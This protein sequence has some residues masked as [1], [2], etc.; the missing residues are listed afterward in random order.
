MPTPTYTLI[1]SSTVTA[2]GGAANI[3]FSSIPNTYTDLMVK[4]SARTTDTNSNIR[5]TINGTSSGYSERMLYNSDGTA[6][7]TSASSS[8]FQFLYAANSSYTSNTF[9][10]ADIYIPNYTG[11]TNKPIYVDSTNENN[12]TS[13]IQNLTAGLWSNSSAIT[14]LTFGTAGGN[15]AQYTT[16]YL[17]GIVKS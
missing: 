7:S 10:S 14:S 15:L 17:Y 12:G 6:Y 11:S 3:S 8:Y 16:A 4:I 5:W 2:S 9:S 1:A 13:I